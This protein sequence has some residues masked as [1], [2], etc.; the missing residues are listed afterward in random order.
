MSL[1]L[2]GLKA[3]L[4]MNSEDSAHDTRLQVCLD[5]AKEEADAWCNN[6]FWQRELNTATGEYEY[7]A[8]PVELDIPSGVKLGVAEYARYLHEKRDWGLD[9]K[10]TETLSQG[11][12]DAE[13]VREEIFSLHMGRYRLITDC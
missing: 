2:D 4:G 3:L 5:A 1:D 11:I 6:P 8:G 9:R 13:A 7:S 10:T 12:K